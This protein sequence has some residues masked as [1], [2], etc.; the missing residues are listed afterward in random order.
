M[1]EASPIDEPKAQTSELTIFLKKR[2][3]TMKAR[4]V[5]AEREQHEKALAFMA[6]MILESLQR[7]DPRVARGELPAH[8]PATLDVAARMQG[9]ARPPRRPL[10][11]YGS[12]Y[13][14]AGGSA[15]GDL[16]PAAGDASISS[17]EIAHEQSPLNQFRQWL[18]EIGVPAILIAAMNSRTSARLISLRRRPANAFTILPT[19]RSTSTTVRGRSLGRTCSARKRTATGF[20]DVGGQRL[21]GVACAASRDLFTLRIIAL[22]DLGKNPSGGGASL[23][24]CEARCRT[25]PVF[26]EASLRVSVAHDIGGGAGRLQDEPHRSAVGKFLTLI[27]RLEIFDLLDCKRHGSPL[28]ETAGETKPRGCNFLHLERKVIVSARD[29]NRLA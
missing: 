14:V 26:E 21:S 12:N 28:G 16:I 22:A 1:V 23:L 25:Q 7:V 6:P 10:S 24:Q 17:S 3:A 20:D 29:F 13:P 8:R 19:W 4:Q 11:H 27:R 9:P 18:A 15:A 5:Q 2:A